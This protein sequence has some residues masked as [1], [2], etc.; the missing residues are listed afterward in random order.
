[1]R[2]YV[3]ITVVAVGGALGSVLRFL[4][5]N[6]FVAKVGP[7]FPWATLTINVSGAFV[8]G[9]VLEVA[10][11][12]AG[13]SPYLRIFLATGILG[14]YTTF[15]TYAFEAY[16]L[17]TNDLIISSVLYAVG[18]LVLGVAAVALGVFVA[19]LAETAIH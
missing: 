3:A 14:G 7:G 8:I 15:S 1:M 5:S 19:R 18:S 16:T 6:W 11:T 13:F 4:V 10:A 12:R 17:G 9:F 2:Q